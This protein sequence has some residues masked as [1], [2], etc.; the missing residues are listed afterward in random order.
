MPQL[1]LMSL[2]EHMLNWFSMESAARSDL[3]VTISEGDQEC[4]VALP[5]IQE[6][7]LKI[8]SAVLE[9]QKSANFRVTQC[10][11]Y[12]SMNSLDVFV[13]SSCHSF[14]VVLYRYLAASIKE[15]CKFDRCIDT[16]QNI[17]AFFA[18]HPWDVS[19]II[20]VLCRVFSFETQIRFGMWKRNG[21]SLEDQMSYYSDPPFCRIFKDLDIF[22]VQCCVTTM[23]ANVFVNMLM[24]HFNLVDLL[25][26]V[27]YPSTASLGEKVMP[28]TVSMLEGMLLVIINLITEL[29]IPCISTEDRNQR[30]RSLIR[31]EVLHKLCQRSFAYTDLIEY[32]CSIG[33]YEQAVIAHLEGI[34][35]EIAVKNR[36]TKEFDTAT[37][38]LK[39]ELW[40]EYDPSFPH[41]K[42]SAHQTAMEARPKPS[43]AS[44][45]VAAPM[46]CYS[47]FADVRTSL[48]SEI[49]LYDIIKSVFF[50]YAAT[51]CVNAPYASNSP[52]RLMGFV[53]S[54]NLLLRCIHLLTLQVHMHCDADS[55]TA[56]SFGEYF[57]IETEQLPYSF[58][59]V[60]CDLFDAISSD[61]KVKYWIEWILIKLEALEPCKEYIASRLE[62]VREQSRQ[63]DMEVR[64]KRAREQ[65]MKKIQSS[66]ASFAATQNMQDVEE[67]SD[68]EAEESLDESAQTACIIC[69]QH[70][71]GEP[72][73]FL[74]YC[75]KSTVLSDEQRFSGIRLQTNADE[76]T[77][78]KGL[79]FHCC[80]H[81]MHYTCFEHFFVRS[82]ASSV[83]QDNILLDPSKGQFQCPMCKRLCNII[84]PSH[85]V[86][87]DVTAPDTTPASL[88]TY[89]FRL[90]EE[91]E[92]QQGPLLPPIETVFS[93]GRALS[94]LITRFGARV[95]DGATAIATETAETSLGLLSRRFFSSMCSIAGL[96]V[97]QEVIGNSFQQ[98]LKAVAYTMA[99]DELN[100]EYNDRARALNTKTIQAALLSIRSALVG[101][102]AVATAKANLSSMLRGQGY[103]QGLEELLRR[104]ITSLATS[105]RE[106]VGR[107]ELLLPFIFRAP[108][109]TL[110]FGLVV[111]LDDWPT[112][113]C[114]ASTVAL[115]AFVQ[116]L[117]SEIAVQDFKGKNSRLL[118]IDEVALPAEVEDIVLCVS[119]CVCNHFNS[120][121]VR[122]SGAVNPHALTLA[123]RRW[124][125]FLNTANKM[126]ATVSGNADA[127]ISLHYSTVIATRVIN[128]WLQPAT[129]RLPLPSS[130]RMLAV[131]FQIVSIA[132][133][134]P[135]TPQLIPLP[136]EYT[137]LH[138]EVV[139]ICDYEFPA[140]CLVCGAIL[141]A[142]GK[143]ACTRHVLSCSGSA[144]LVFLLQDCALLFI[145]E[146]RCCYFPSPYI[147]VNGEK[148]KHYKGRP[149]YFDSKRYISFSY[150]TYLYSS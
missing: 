112:A 66:A 115:G 98:I 71:T 51:I 73:G 84:V 16:I 10:R 56:F 78:P 43:K 12:R 72:I 70:S 143:G 138:R 41:L 137:E 145:N 48:L 91:E 90:V 142:H 125:S 22:L 113:M 62:A 6:F 55:S 123:Y 77:P 96:S 28:G 34:L 105:D 79:Y 75:Q 32:V 20:E 52:Y 86:L 25:W 9:W 83:N 35:E 17:L 147:D 107:C 3:V 130:P 141:D 133:R 126:V 119:R 129:S 8:V 68:D 109:D 99:V 61:D 118:P 122:W 59:L 106:D 57:T 127:H 131:P 15:C 27:V 111:H 29:P 39:S 49:L 87:V 18:D 89:L 102:N 108:I 19:Y 103:T 45:Y 136:T 81:C 146:G 82:V 50:S 58:L 80:G 40:G 95:G 148:H 33:D 5:S 46:A 65:A 110:N 44:P 42:S 100:T 30:I 114:F 1:S 120:L 47:L 94:R 124:V 31:R 53:S 24:Y 117:V 36:V 135:A 149:L 23:N 144:G 60:L 13:P 54:E 101:L 11:Q 121:G 76:L 14:H 116:I 63:K 97:N 92:E 139:S 150:Y 26:V 93:F 38:S 140:L 128:S 88:E 64:R 85:P 69:H 37:F 67:D 4:E 104:N 21:H 134:I 7:I 2:L 132:Y 74:G